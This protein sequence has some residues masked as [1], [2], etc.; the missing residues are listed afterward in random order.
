VLGKY[1]WVVERLISWLHVF[2]N[3][4]ATTEKTQEMQFAFFNLALSLICFRFL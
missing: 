4:P 1:R 3:D 2:F